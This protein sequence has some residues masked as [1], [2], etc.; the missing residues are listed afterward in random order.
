ML[1]LLKILSIV[2][3]SAWSLLR[4]TEE[5]IGAWVRHATRQRDLGGLSWA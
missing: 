2:V 3:V 4:G 5:A 1:H